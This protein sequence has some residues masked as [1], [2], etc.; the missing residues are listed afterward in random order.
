M[1]TKKVYT[2][3]ETVT[4]TLGGVDHVFREPTGNDLVAYEQALKG[5]EVSELEGMAILASIL[6]ENK[7]YS[8]EY[9]L[10]LSF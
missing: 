9:F 4:V 6:S 8:S 7:V 3:L 5:K 2:E 1:A 10:G